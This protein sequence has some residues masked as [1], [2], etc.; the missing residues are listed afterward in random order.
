MCFCLD[1][2][3]FISYKQ[4]FSPFIYKISNNEFPFSHYE[5]NTKPKFDYFVTG[6][7]EVSTLIHLCG[8]EKLCIPYAEDFINTNEN[9]ECIYPWAQWS[10]LSDIILQIYLYK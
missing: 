9:K 3:L 2:I 4:N 7:G 1:I 8:S 10:S 6:N 5:N